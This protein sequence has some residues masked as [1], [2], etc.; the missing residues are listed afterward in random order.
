MAVSFSVPFSNQ[1]DKAGY[2]QLPV[3]VIHQDARTGQETDL[4]PQALHYDP[5]YLQTQQRMGKFLADDPGLT[6]QICDYAVTSAKDQAMWVGGEAAVVTG[7]QGLKNLGAE[8]VASFSNAAGSAGSRAFKQVVGEGVGERL[9]GDAAKNV[10]R[11]MGEKAGGE[12]AEKAGQ[13]ILKGIPVVG[14]AMTLGL[15][16]WELFQKQQEIKAYTEAVGEEN[17]VGVD[18]EWLENIGK[19][20]INTGTGLLTLVPGVGLVVSTGTSIA[21]AGL[22][23]AYDAQYDNKTAVDWYH[24]L[25]PTLENCRASGDIFVISSQQAEYAIL[26][27]VE[28]RDPE[29][30]QKLR[31]RI[32]MGDPAFEIVAARVFTE[33][34]IH[35]QY[36][37]SCLSQLHKM[38]VAGMLQCAEEGCPF[39][40][41]FSP[42][43]KAMQNLA[44]Q[45][46]MYGAAYAPEPGAEAWSGEL[47]QPVTVQ[48]SGV[49]SHELPAERKLAFADESHVARLRAGG[50]RGGMENTANAVTPQGFQA[51]EMQRRLQ[52][53]EQ[54]GYSIN[55]N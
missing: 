45:E 17:A 40:I 47:V 6:Q 27:S 5:Q 7:Y 42:S 33:I 52:K 1:L 31:R 12:I 3:Q 43:K 30:G 54:A 44:Q 19:C 55:L 53:A 32:E 16:A 48:P 22:E 21:G 28:E 2:V 11:E 23:M 8:G 46:Q 24:Q 9:L 15:S 10:A 41:L 37:V 18:K 25:E 26:S 34:A 51:M 39:E 35:Q 13:G 50:Y 49:P 29:L 20:A 38:D 36:D 4:V 14:T